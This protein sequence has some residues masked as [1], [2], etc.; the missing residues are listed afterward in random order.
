MLARP[1]SYCA[2]GT[3]LLDPRANILPSEVRDLRSRKALIRHLHRTCAQILDIRPLPE[4]PAITPRTVLEVLGVDKTVNRKV[5]LVPD[6]EAQDHRSYIGFPGRY[7]APSSGF[8]L[9]V[10]ALK[11]PGARELP[12]PRFAFPGLIELSTG[13]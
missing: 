13:T 5:N 11:S 6:M 1:G 2:P 3:L 7:V 10:T 9:P 12:A 4:R 8:L